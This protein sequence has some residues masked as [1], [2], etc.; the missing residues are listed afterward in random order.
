M[1]NRVLGFSGYGSAGLHTHTQVTGYTGS[2]GSGLQVFV[3]R[4]ENTRPVGNQLLA[5]GHGGLDSMGFSGLIVTGS[6]GIVGFGSWVTGLMGLMGFN[7]QVRR[8]SL[9]LAGICVL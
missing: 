1:E 8:K 7:A 2:R 5:A 9:C 4:P 6:P 3:V